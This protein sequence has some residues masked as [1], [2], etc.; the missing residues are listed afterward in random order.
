MSFFFSNPAVPKKRRLRKLGE[1]AGATA[2]TPT[3]DELWHAA[4][5]PA[6]EHRAEEVVEEVATSPARAATPPA[7][8]E[9]A[10]DKA[11]AE[12]AAASARPD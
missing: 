7:E 8:Q 3:V 12:A 2:A 10:V 1:M 6:D 11:A 4:T 9:A 5:P